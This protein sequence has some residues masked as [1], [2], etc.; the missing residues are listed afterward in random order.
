MIRILNN[1]KVMIR[2]FSRPDFE[3]FPDLPKALDAIKAKYIEI[4]AAEKEG[5]Q[6]G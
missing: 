4:E 1:G 3:M 2:D 6:D 5:P